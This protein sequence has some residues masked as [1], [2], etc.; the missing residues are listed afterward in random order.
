MLNEFWYL[1]GKEVNTVEDLRESINGFILESKFESFAVD[2]W[3][4]YGCML[5]DETMLNKL[6]ELK[7]SYNIYQR[8]KIERPIIFSKEIDYNLNTLI[9]EN[10][11]ELDDYAD[12]ET[13][14]DKLLKEI[15][16]QVNVYIDSK[17]EEYKRNNLLLYSL[18]YETLEK[19]GGENI[20]SQIDQ[21]THLKLNEQSEWFKTNRIKGA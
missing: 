1:K 3:D 15:K 12:A 2:Q 20:A 17:V 13:N 7:K 11:D 19:Q 8:K 10:L 5:T 14:M 18:L 21:M 6:N 9:I 16:E 4:L